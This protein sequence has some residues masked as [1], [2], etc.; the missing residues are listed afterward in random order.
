[1]TGGQG[2]S[3]NG[4]NISNGAL[5]SDG[6]IVSGASLSGVSA[7]GGLSGRT[8]QTAANVGGQAVIGRANGGAASIS[9]AVSSPVKQTLQK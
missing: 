6:R 9:V 2:V 5:G 1:M 8:R 4:A 7:Q 3:I